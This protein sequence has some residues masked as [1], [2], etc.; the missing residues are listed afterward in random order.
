MC[1]FPSPAVPSSPGPRPSLPPPVRP[2]LSSGRGS[3][4]RLVAGGVVCR[5]AGERLERLE[6]KKIKERLISFFK[7]SF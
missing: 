6:Y 4:G 3:S 7:R 2:S 1:F 5:F